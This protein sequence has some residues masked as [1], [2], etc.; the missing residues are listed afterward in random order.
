MIYPNMNGFW[1]YW[2]S[3]TSKH[4]HSR[5]S[6]QHILSGFEEQVPFF[7]SSLFFLGPNL[8]PMEVPGLGAESELQL[9]AY[10][11]VTPD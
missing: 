10:A 6:Y 5:V 3:S 2:E 9:Q 11:T 7:F 4:K 1:P 8:W